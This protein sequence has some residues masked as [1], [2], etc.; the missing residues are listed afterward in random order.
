MSV[1]ARS[2]ASTRAL[3]VNEPTVRFT[4]RW[5]DEGR[6]AAIQG[7][8]R[9]SNPYRFH[10]EHAQHDAWIDGFESFQH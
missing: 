2:E 10:S 1:T 5:L 4:S 9:F 6:A 8:S 3:D 7:L